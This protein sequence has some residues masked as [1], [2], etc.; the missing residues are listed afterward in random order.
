[1][2]AW[3][4]GV[5][6]AHLRGRQ[7]SQRSATY[8]RPATGTVPTIC[9]L[10]ATSG[11][12]TDASARL[13]SGRHARGAL[14][15]PL[16]KVRAPPTERSEPA[17]TRR[18]ALQP[19]TRREGLQWH[20]SEGRQTRD[21]P[22]ADNRGSRSM[23][24]YNA[25]NAA[26]YLPRREDCRGKHGRHSVA[27][28]LIGHNARPSDW[29]EAHYHPRVLWGTSSF[30]GREPSEEVVCKE[31]ELPSML[32]EPI[33]L[34]PPSPGSTCRQRRR[35]LARALCARRRD[36]APAPNSLPVLP[37]PQAFRPQPWR[38]AGMA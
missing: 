9:G 13:G 16:L 7:C 28:A 14:E 26:P 27:L 24:D 10:L 36:S 30:P 3:L 35:A 29:P 15:S 4:L 21:S 17:P 11:P 34:H 8:P 18:P 6:D 5:Y 2:L 31:L 20:T 25:G 23:N 1:M 38:L 33:W 32:S 37:A 19:R 12:T 22:D